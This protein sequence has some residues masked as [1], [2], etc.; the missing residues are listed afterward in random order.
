[1][2]FSTRLRRGFAKQILPY[3]IGA[4]AMGFSTRLRRGF[5]KQILPYF[6][7]AP[8]MGFS[9]RLRRGPACVSRPESVAPGA[10]KRNLGNP[11][12]HPPSPL[13]GRQLPAQSAALSEG[14]TPMP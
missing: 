4:P 9:T 14:E 10:A 13:R 11:S 12:P 6:I 1:M 5:A 3:F 8:A 2:G 7:G